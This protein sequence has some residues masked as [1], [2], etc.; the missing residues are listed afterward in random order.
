MSRTVPAHAG[1]VDLSKEYVFPLPERPSPRPCGRGGFKPIMR[2]ASCKLVEV[3]AHAGGV[4]LSTLSVEHA[5][6]ADGPRPCGRGGFKQPHCMEFSV[7]P[8]PR[9]CGRGGFKLS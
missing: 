7:H 6:V 5:A 8:C 3:P 4:D 1:G 9:P 2:K